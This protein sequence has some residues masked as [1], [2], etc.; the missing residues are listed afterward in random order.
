M[1]NDLV[2]VGSAKNLSAYFEKPGVLEA[3]QKSAANNIDPQRVT[4][5]V[6]RFASD[7][8]QR[9]LLNCTMASLYTAVSECISLGMEPRLGRA[10]FVPYGNVCTFM[11]GYQGM[12]DLARNGGVHATV[13]A[14]F[15]GDEFQFVEGTEERITHIPNL[16]TERIEENFRYAYVVSKFADGHV[17]HTV[18]NKKEIDAVRRRSKAGGSGPWV[19]DYVEMAKKTV[20]RRAAKNWPLSVDAMEAFDRD[21]DRSYA[22]QQF[23][24]TAGVKYSATAAI[25]NRLIGQDSNT[26]KNDDSDVFDVEPTESGEDTAG[27]PQETPEPQQAPKAPKDGRI[28]PAQAK[29]LYAIAKGAGW[30]DD[31]IHRV[32][33]EYGYQHTNEIGWKQYE[34][35]VERFQGANKNAVDVADDKIPF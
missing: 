31:D 19:T 1:G 7:P 12:L 32:V 8:K 26:T 6:C 28:S 30:S 29:R 25:K 2:L 22:G 15:V 18:M 14:V 10:Y 27:E 13:H 34:E 33:A 3:L 5:I 17:S 4:K 11:L 20:V 23:D 9:S 35:I 24:V 16:D 21:D